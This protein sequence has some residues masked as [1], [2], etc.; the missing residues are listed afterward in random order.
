VLVS[1]AIQFFGIG[2]SPAAKRMLHVLHDLSWPLE[3]LFLSICHDRI[4]PVTAI[5][6]GME[7]LDD[8]QGDMLTEIRHRSRAESVNSGMLDISSSLPGASDRSLKPSLEG[9]TGIK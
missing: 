4:G 2:G 8:N 5:N 3:L 7:L 9:N 1:L 6:R